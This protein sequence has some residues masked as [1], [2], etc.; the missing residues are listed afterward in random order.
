MAHPKSK[1]PRQ[2]I[3][4]HPNPNPLPGKVPAALQQLADSQGQPIR[5]MTPEGTAIINPTTT[6]HKGNI[7]MAQA[8]T[9][10]KN[11]NPTKPTL[12]PKPTN[13]STPDTAAK[14][15]KEKRSRVSWVS[16][17][18]PSY[19]VRSFKAV[20]DKLGAPSDHKGQ[21]MIEKAPGVFGQRRDPA[22]KAAREASKVQAKA[23]YDAMTDE[24]KMAHAKSKR[25]AKQAATA[26]KAAADRAE[27]KRQIMAEIAAGTL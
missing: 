15:K 24:Q 1:S 26:A 23:A 2:A 21:K 14:P 27:L 25:E 4:L 17:T 6:T 19:V 11:P 8:P 9:S 3:T 10:N 22:E 20:T 12:A 18:D 7:T 13:G 5:L 16:P